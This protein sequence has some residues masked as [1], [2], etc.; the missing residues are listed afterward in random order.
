MHWEQPKSLGKTIEAVASN[1]PVKI[2]YLVPCDDDHRTQMILDATFFESYTRWGGAYSLIIPTRKNEFTAE[3][4][5]EWLRKYDPDFI[6]S[7]IDLD[8]EFV[9]KIDQLSC[10][11]AFLTHKEKVHEEEEVH[12]RSYLPRWDHYIKPVSSMST[13]QSPASYPQLV[14]EG[15]SQEPTV[16]T[17]FERDP[18]D[19]FIADNFGTAFS[20]HNWINPIPG[21][22]NTLCVVP[23]DLPANMSTGTERCLSTAEALR[24]VSDH[25]AIPIVRFAM[26]YS[27][28]IPRPESLAWTSAFQLFIGSTSS[29]RIH[30]WNSRH[31]GNKWGDNTNS[32]ILDPAFFDDEA[33]VKELGNYLN[34]N[35]FIGYGN[36]PHHVRLHSV[37][38]EEGVLREIQDKL[39]RHTWNTVSIDRL[40]NAPSIP[41]RKELEERIHVNASDNTTIR[42][43]EDLTKIVANEPAH[44]MYVPQQVKGIVHGQWM[45]ELSIQRHNNLSRYSNVADV[46]TLPKRLKIARAFTSQLAKPTL[47]GRLALAPSTESTFGSRS[48]KDP[49]FYDIQ[50]PSDE[51]FFRHLALEFFL[52]PHDDLRAAEP[53][54]GY[55]NLAIS[56]KGQN[57]RGVISL[58]GS[59]STAYGT[60]TKRFWRKVLSQAKEDTTKPLTFSRDK[61]NSL[62]TTDIPTLER[63]MTEFRL[64]DVGETRNYL[65]DALTDTLERLVQSNVFYQVAHWRCEYCGHQN[66]RSFDNMKLKNQCDICAADFFSPID[67]EWEY[68]LNNFVYRSLTKH[69]GLSVL[70]SL[71]FLQDQMRTG[72]FWYLPE[73]DLY[74]S[75]DRRTVSNEIDILCVINSAFC[76]VEVK[77]SASSFLNTPGAI[78]KFVKI[79]ALLRPDVAVLSFIGYCKEDADIPTTKEKLAAEATAIRERIGPYTRLDI[80]VAQDFKRFTDFSGDLGWRGKRVAEYR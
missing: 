2:V 69:N 78:D 50:L 66:S 5:D 58:L 12:W 15:R 41:T 29:D 18:N 21:F 30:F 68:E 56:D 39:A 20:V 59:L 26:A 35:N 49:S 32:L 47:A 28:S 46:W 60:L 53:R 45:V 4:Y 40:F 80:L 17:Q 76:A 42:L 65:K 36:S 19:R 63:I 75:D 67:L 24:A 55:Q 38:V 13:V 57:L 44:F 79:I 72:S 1:R 31:I 74:E 16:L 23:A 33:L 6:Y 70:W 22:F 34:K 54:V 3:E 7:Y 52:Y 37:S 10:P 8:A 64:A 62:I 25:K 71:G 9:H 73:V 48:V 11:I 61:L 27:G 77:K 43:S 14:H 51:T